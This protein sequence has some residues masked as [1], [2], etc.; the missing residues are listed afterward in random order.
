MPKKEAVGQKMWAH[1]EPGTNKMREMECLL[2]RERIYRK[3]DDPYVP[4]ALIKSL[5]LHFLLSHDIEATD[6]PEVR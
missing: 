3:G 4:S 1:C 6:L 2:C 5:R